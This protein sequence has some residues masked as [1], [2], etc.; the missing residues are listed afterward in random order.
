MTT[1]IY[2]TADAELGDCV[3]ID[4]GADPKCFL[5]VDS[6]RAGGY[7][8]PYDEL[9]TKEEYHEVIQDRRGV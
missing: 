5:T 9:P 1:G 8:P 4:W 6:Y 7:Q 3:R 2:K